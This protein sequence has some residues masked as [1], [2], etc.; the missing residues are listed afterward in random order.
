MQH[1]KVVVVVVVVVVVRFDVELRRA[2]R[3]CQILELCFACRKLPR[4]EHVLK[5]IAKTKQKHAEHDDSNSN[6][7]QSIDATTTTTLAPDAPPVR[8]S[9]SWAAQCAPRAPACASPR[10]VCARNGI[11]QSI[12]R[13]RHHHHRRPS[14]LLSSMSYE[15][16]NSSCRQ[17]LPTHKVSQHETDDYQ[18]HQLRIHTHRVTKLCHSELAGMIVPLRARWRRCSRR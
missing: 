13:R 10:C 18:E 8:R 1:A 6:R 4:F 7:R 5:R 3:I 14:S 2:L 11:D 9:R 12:D 15:Q 17:I 16:T